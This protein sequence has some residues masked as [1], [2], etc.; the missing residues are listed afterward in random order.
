MLARIVV[1]I[2]ETNL[3]VVQGKHLSNNYLRTT[4][5]NMFSVF[6]LEVNVIY[7]EGLL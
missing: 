6:L 5:G 1:A 3:Q 4:M 2:G 7:A